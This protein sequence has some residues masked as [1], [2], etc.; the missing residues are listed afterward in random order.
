MSQ[1]MN[2]SITPSSPAGTFFVKQGD[3]DRELTVNLYDENGPWIIPPGSSVKIR[4]TKPSG[5]GFEVSGTFSG[6]VVT[7]VTTETMTNEWGRF[8]CEVR[9][10]SSDETTNLGTAVIYFDVV[11]D[12]HEGATNGDAPALVNTITALV[13]TMEGLVDSMHAL[14]VEAVTLDPGAPA[15]AVYDPLTNKITFGIPQGIVTI[16]GSI[17]FTDANN[18]G[19]VVITITE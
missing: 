2:V 14:T 15:T 3:I 11:R 4:A 7:I 10:V 19:N 12:P 8:P 1:I 5:L 17:V 18:D 9:I 16:E 13:N 6:N